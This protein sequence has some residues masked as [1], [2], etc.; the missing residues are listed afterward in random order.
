MTGGLLQWER[1]KEQERTSCT[2]GESARGRSGRSTPDEGQKDPVLMMRSLDGL[3]WTARW[4]VRFRGMTEE[5]G[6]RGEPGSGPD[7]GRTPELFESKGLNL[8]RPRHGP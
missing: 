7:G 3:A 8:E 6:I 2:L 5:A 4:M 1:F